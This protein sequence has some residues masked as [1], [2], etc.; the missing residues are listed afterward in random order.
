MG[1]DGPGAKQQVEAALL[2]IGGL[3]TFGLAGARPLAIGWATVDFD[4]AVAELAAAFGLTVEHFEPSS[5]SE[6]LGCACRVAPGVLSGGASLAILEPDTEGRLA[7]SLARLNEGPTVIWVGLDK[8]AAAAK[9]LETAGLVLAAEQGGPFG[10]ER[11]I[12]DGRWQG[13]QGLLVEAPD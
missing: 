4:R 2:A 1:R 6:T 3:L 5:R 8:P 9:T 7:A 11:L 10:P 13:F 12:V